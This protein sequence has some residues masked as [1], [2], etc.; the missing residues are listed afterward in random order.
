MTFE[1]RREVTQDLLGLLADA[2]LYELARFRIERNLA[3]RED[4]SAGAHGLRVRPDGRRR[5]LRLDDLS[6]CTDTLFST[7]RNK[8]RILTEG[9]R[10]RQKQPP[11]FEYVS[12][13]YE[14]RA[15]QAIDEKT[16]R[17]PERE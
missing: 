15:E 17:D 7:F 6:H 14:L 3:R 11:G 1:H 12:H 2:A 9:R 8:L 13:T 4:E 10:V 16:K 5:A